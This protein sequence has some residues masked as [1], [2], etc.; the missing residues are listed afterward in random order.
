MLDA[1]S[2]LYLYLNTSQKYFEYLKYLIK[3]RVYFS[4]FLSREGTN[5]RGQ[6]L[7]GDQLLPRKK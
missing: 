4:G 6:D 5:G 7:K 2:I 3:Y 1:T